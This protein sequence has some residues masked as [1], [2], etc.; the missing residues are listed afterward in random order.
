[1]TL[2]QWLQQVTRGLAERE[3]RLLTRAAA[4]LTDNILVSTPDGPLP[5][6]PLRGI[7]PSPTTYSGVWNW[8]SAFHAIAVAR[9]DAE[10]AREQIRIFLDAQLPSGALPDV[11]FADGRVV[12]TFGKPPVMPW[13]AM[14]VNHM[15]PGDDFARGAYERFV[16]YE[17]YWRRE[18]G[19]DADGLFHYDSAAAAPARRGEAN[20]ESG[21]DDSVRWD[22]PIYDLWPVDLNAYMVMLYRALESFAELLACPADARRWRSRGEELAARIEARL[23]DDAA[24]AYLDYDYRRRAFSQALTPASFMPL[25]IGAAS[26]AR[27]ERMAAL[28][29]DPR[30][31][32]PGMPTVAY[33]HPAYQSGGYWRGPTW[34]NVAWFALCGLRRYGYGATAEAIRA[35]LLDW[36]DRNTD[37]LYEY[38]DSRSGQGLGARQFGWTAVFL[39]E[40]ILG[41]DEEHQRPV[42]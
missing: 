29:A 25:Y 11:I 23:W 5:W 40:L 17:A 10:L 30:R 7:C 1:M 33:D 22:T 24:G 6:S 39:I 2:D 21:W 36:C 34:L 4:T 3:R 26:P 32:F 28:A 13:A 42:R 38:Y 16:A 35:T 18:R 14:R 9:W 12:T 19:G 8:D 20:M 31:L 37:T 41:W 15:A 27:A